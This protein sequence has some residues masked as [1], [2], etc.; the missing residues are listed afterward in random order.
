MSDEKVILFPKMKLPV[1][2]QTVEEL[3]E[4]ILEYKK[5][6]A[7]EISGMILNLVMIEMARAGVQID[8]EDPE[9]MTHTIF[10]YEAIKSVYMFAD[11]VYHPLQ[12]FADV[13]ITESGELIEL[14]IIKTNGEDM[15]DENIENAIDT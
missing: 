3:Q 8:D 15:E 13:M 5:D 4:K 1:P 12:D 11:N 10:L 2:P 14:E 6:Y 9:V 7:A